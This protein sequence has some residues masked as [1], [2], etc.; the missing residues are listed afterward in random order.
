M[1]PGALAQEL[2]PRLQGR[3]ASPRRFQRW[4]LPP[5]RRRQMKRKSN[6][7]A[8]CATSFCHLWMRCERILTSTTRATASYV[9]CGTARKVSCI[10]TLY[11]IT[12]ALNT[13]CS[14]KWWNN[15]NGR[16]WRG[17]AQ[18]MRKKRRVFIVVRAH[19]Q[20]NACVF[21]N[22]HTATA[23]RERY[24]WRGSSHTNKRH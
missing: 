3:L 15:W 11:A 19:C 22:P 4:L 21:D 14:G 13:P 24:C 7:N 17:C 8:R 12:C 10:R 2:R 23:L 1:P 5:A 16:R 6:T 9:P 18:R 20:R